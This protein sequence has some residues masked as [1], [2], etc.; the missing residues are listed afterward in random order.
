MST[1]IITE[2]PSVARRIANSLGNPESIKRNGIYYY[3]VGN[4]FV[5]PSVGHV[6]ALR[7]KGAG[8][9]RYPVFD[10]DW[11]PIYK[12]NKESK[13]AKDYIENIE[14]L[15]RKCD[16]FINACDYDIEGEVIGYNIIRFLCKTDPLKR[17]VQRMKF[18]TLTRDSILNA[19][20]NLEYTNKGM[21]DAGITRHTLDW[22]WGINLSRALTIAVRRAKGY[23][24]LST[25]RVQGPALKILVTREEQIEKFIPEKYWEIEMISLKGKGK[26]SSMHI[27]GRF[28]KKESAEKCTG[29]LY[30]CIHQLPQNIKSAIAQGLEFQGYP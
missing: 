5:V 20:N 8:I 24:T 7:E 4:N 6:F 12:A 17:N 15:A 11:V 10:I 21:A 2:K 19:Y 25:G 9:W 23:T 28:K 26:I 14:F 27:N 30:K 16:K 29:P 22:F 18:S 1:L 13:F 3:K